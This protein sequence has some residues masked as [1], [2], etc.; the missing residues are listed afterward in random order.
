[1]MLFARLSTCRYVLVIFGIVLV[2]SLGVGLASMYAFLF[3]QILR[4]VFNRYIAIF[5]IAMN[6]YCKKDINV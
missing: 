4:R 1:M 2:L 3:E 6:N 5:H